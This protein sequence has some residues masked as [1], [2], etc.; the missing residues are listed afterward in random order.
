MANL[1]HSLD[2][3]P[4]Y[5][6][7]VDE[8]SQVLPKDVKFTAHHLSTPP[9]T[10]DAL[11][12]SPA[13][14][15]NNAQYGN[16]IE[17]TERRA[18][19]PLRTYCE[20]H[21][22][23]ISIDSLDSK[24]KV[25]V[26][27]LEIYIYTTAYSTIIFVAKAD[28]TGYLSLL[29]L[30]KATPS[31]IREITT[32]FITFL[33]ASRRRK[34]KQCIVN[35]FAR[36]QS[37][38]L[39]PGS[40][41][42]S[43][44]HVL[45]DRGLVRWWCRVLNPLLDGSES[46][47]GRKIWQH[48]QGYLVIPGLDEHETR[49][50]LPRSPTATKWTL[51][52][53]LEHMSPY[54]TDPATYGSTVPPRCLIPTYPDDPKARFVEELEESTSERLKLSGGW[55]SLRTLDQFWEMM[56][57]RQECSSGRMT[58]FAWVVFDPPRSAKPIQSRPSAA[59]IPTPSASYSGP[60][61]DA[62]RLQTPEPNQELPSFVTPQSTPSKSTQSTPMKPRDRPKKRV[63]KVL[64]GR[65]VP[66]QPRIKTHQRTHF[67]ENIETPHYYWPEEGRGKVI[68]DESGYKRA[69]ELLLH[70]E[71]GTLESAISSTARWINE[72]NVGSDWDQ[73]IIGRRELPAPE[74]AS[75]AFS[76]AVNDLSSMI[77]K[78]KRP[79]TELAPDTSAP[80]ETA[81]VNTLGAGLVRKKAKIT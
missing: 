56:A 79:A 62:T 34:G 81:T 54:T 64:K 39:F 36:A 28:S 55:K 76:G 17:S 71:F 16:A 60:P 53:P 6:A 9:T 40:V 35:L 14:P 18:R 26:L 19:K 29:K 46:A 66:R 59:V 3:I 22:L 61:N 23:T 32:T 65:I 69:V 24:E 27:A 63:K 31:P 77:K 50:F 42:N 20:K 1:R 11:C 37:Q 72:V 70:L 45:D 4:D 8:L 51:G 68:L 25:L 43:S 44:K 21:F 30:P 52:H 7:L 67:P 13:Y 75:S 47:S 10:T 74:P 5:D 80:S 48:I 38:Y 57:F 78:K 49:M 12:H 15:P 41:T 2:P 73:E 33:I 58:G